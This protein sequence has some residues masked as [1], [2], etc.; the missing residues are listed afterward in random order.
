MH[1]LLRPCLREDSVLSMFKC[2]ACRQWTKYYWDMRH[3]LEKALD[4]ATDIRRATTN[5]SIYHLD[6]VFL[7]SS[8]S[9]TK[10]C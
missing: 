4:V 8:S 1:P 2:I 10:S 3:D 7:S 9:C 5:L 6:H